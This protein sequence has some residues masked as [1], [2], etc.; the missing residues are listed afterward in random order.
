MILTCPTCGTRYQTDR[1]RLA[2]PGGNVRCAKCLAVWFHAVSEAEETP[3]PDSSEA[4]S[5]NK[6]ADIGLPENDIVQSERAAN[7]T[8][9]ALVA[10]WGVLLIFM[11]TFAWAA[12]AF[13]HEIAT[14]WPQ[15]SSYY[16]AIN[17]P[18]N[19]QGLALIDIGYDR[20]VENGESVL[21]ISGRVTNVS[22]AELAVPGIRVSLHDGDEREL[23]SWTINAGVPLLRPG[24]SQPFLTRLPNPPAE[25]RGVDLSFVASVAP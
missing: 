5:A 14:V 20:A 22:V 9:L 21:R 8:R 17:L 6:S 15:S 16:A 23:Y 3:E 13:R 24:Q 19:I 1:A 12:I 11:G 4:L 18:V 10:G 7:R 2:P 25:M